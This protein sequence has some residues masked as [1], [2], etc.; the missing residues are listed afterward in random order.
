MKKL[1]VIMLLLVS[2]QACTKSEP[3]VVAAGQNPEVCYRELYQKAVAGDRTALTELR[4]Q[5]EKGNPKAQN[6][7]G[8]MYLQGRG[9]A[10]NYS[11]AMKWYRKAA[12][13]GLDVAQN[14]LGIMYGNGQGAAQ[15]FAE[16]RRWFRMAADQ[17]NADARRN[18][19]LPVPAQ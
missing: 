14:S 4:Q 15:N 11:E 3:S 10:Q 7:L 19:Q 13:Q 1:M 17:G 2:V 9:V 16:A 5:A 6:N 8:L 18:L 12:E